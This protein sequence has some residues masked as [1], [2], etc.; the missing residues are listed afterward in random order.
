M[1]QHNEPTNTGTIILTVAA[2]AALVFTSLSV[3]QT[4]SQMNIMSADMNI[5]VSIFIGMMGSISTVWSIRTFAQT[6]RVKK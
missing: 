2:V 1:H 6:L 4:F 5:G 3:H